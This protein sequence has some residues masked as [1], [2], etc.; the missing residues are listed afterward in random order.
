MPYKVFVPIILINVVL[1]SLLEQKTEYI[2]EYTLHAR[3]IAATLCLALFTQKYWPNNAKKFFPI[4]WYF[5]VII[6]VPILSTL[7]LLQSKQ[8]ILHLSDYLLSTLILVILFDWLIALFCMVI[9]FLVGISISYYLQGH[10]SWN[11]SE[12]ETLA[13]LYIYALV[14][15]ATSALTH[16]NTISNLKV[17][18]LKDQLNKNLEREVIS[19][20]TALEES[21][22][23]NNYF[24]NNVSHE[25]KTPVQVITNICTNLLENW[26]ES[27]E[28]EK[29]ILLQQ[30]N[31]S[32]NNLFSLINNVLD[33]S[34]FNSGKMLFDMKI[35]NIEDAVKNIVQELIPLASARDVK[36]EVYKKKHIE[37]RSLFDLERVSQVIR[38]LLANAIQY[39]KPSTVIRIDIQ[40]KYASLPSGITI[41]GLCVSVKDQGSGVPKKDLKK[42][43][44]PFG[45]SSTSK[46]SKSKSGL[47]LYIA[48]EIVSAHNGLL[49]AETNPNNQ[50]ATFYCVIPY[51]NNRVRLD[52]D[53]S[54]RKKYN[55]LFVD[56][57]EGCRVAG[58][59]LLDNLG[60]NVKTFATGQDLL[61]YIKYTEK[62]TDLI[63]LDIL[64]P[65]L[66]GIEVLKL[67]RSHIKYKHTPI[68][69]QTG[70]KYDIDTPAMNKCAPIG[71]I[72]KPYN[73][74][75]INVEIERF[76]YVPT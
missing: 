71:Y 62:K 23:S 51:P 34:K 40:Q 16:S 13:F 2:P 19:R 7:S 57:E 36:V 28:E 72:A 74:E 29:I 38:N 44:E 67:L 27:K 61:D 14:Y 76:L 26:K 43:F 31:Y 59:M 73:K 45:Q 46:Y 24:L 10:L 3:F 22:N 56:D 30:L 39:T 42:I 60:Y 32:G 66:G 11:A 17:L 49:W 21:L 25:I 9:G 69:L 50:G 5:T 15:I 6:S 18:R 64:M 48:S 70:T 55:L 8:S 47:G 41:N 75:E 4:F 37:V 63:L 35:H 12:T 54:A 68:I 52:E 53:K 20:T 65:D 1:L 33:I 58:R